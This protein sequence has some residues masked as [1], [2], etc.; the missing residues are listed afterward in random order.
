MIF[1]LKRELNK[2]TN[3]RPILKNKIGIEGK[4]T[5]VI[6]IQ[7]II[8]KL[9]LII[10]NL[11]ETKNNWFYWIQL[12]GEYNMFLGKFY[13]NQQNSDVMSFLIYC[14]EALVW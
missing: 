13:N 11:W 8:S 1:L 10:I 7:D 5:N 14:C 12:Y 4:E 2:H 9:S 3:T 6:N